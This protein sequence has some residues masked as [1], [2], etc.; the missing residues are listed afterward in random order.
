MQY[1]VA[2]H[3]S[4]A[5]DL[6]EL[7]G[8]VNRQ[9]GTHTALK[10]VESIRAYCLDSRH[11]FN[12]VRRVRTFSPVYVLSD[13][14]AASASHLQYRMKLYTSWVSS[15]V[16]APLISVVLRKK[17]TKRHSHIRAFAQSPSICYSVYVRVGL[18]H[19]RLPVSPKH[20]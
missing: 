14:V 7:A 9:S 15:M 13:F 2:F 11:F 16:A 17:P 5:R 3:P 10:F 8:Y 20:V 4:A 19:A 12:E 1:R 18:R 6:D